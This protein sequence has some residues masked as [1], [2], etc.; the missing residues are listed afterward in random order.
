M[1]IFRKVKMQIDKGRIVTL[2]THEE[3]LQQKGLYS[4]MYC[5]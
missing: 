1:P 4:D 5:L 3:L 2:G